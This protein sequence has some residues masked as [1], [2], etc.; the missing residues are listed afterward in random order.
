MDTDAIVAALRSPTG[1]SAELLRMARAGALTLT[2]TVP[3]C[4]EYEAV[5]TRADHIEAAGLSREDV[6]VFLDAV[7]SLIEPAEFWFLWRPQLR[8]PGDELVLEA[9]IN[10]R[11]E[12]IVTFNRR[13]FTPAANRFGVAI[14]LPAEA[15]RRTSL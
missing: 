8:D 12:G 7:V 13:D 15:L 11:A 4:L 9:A 2:A 6:G 5:C 10:G 1:A 3:L 14:M